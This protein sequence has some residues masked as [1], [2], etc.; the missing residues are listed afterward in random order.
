MPVAI[1]EPVSS[2]LNFSDRS[3]TG[4]GAGFVLNDLGDGVSLLRWL[5]LDISEDALLSV[6][7]CGILG[8]IF[9]Q[10][11]SSDA[12]TR[13]IDEGLLPEN[14]QQS[15]NSPLWRGYEGDSSGRVRQILRY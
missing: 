15:L 12:N 1:L 5:L 6:R 13:G 11:S 9:A 4:V 2:I 3:S 14:V 7:L 8:V 10:T